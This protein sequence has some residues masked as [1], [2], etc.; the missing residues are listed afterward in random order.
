MNKQ[1]VYNKVRDHLLGMRRQSKDCEGVY[2]YRSPRGVM[3]AAGALIKDEFYSED[4]EHCVVR[5]LNVRNALI[6]SG[7]RDGYL[8]MVSDLQT[9]HDESFNWTKSGKG[10]NVEGKK[11][12][13]LVATHH[14][15]L[16]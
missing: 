2:T 9:V 12:L 11:A 15:L 4:L 7:V 14:G 10:L 8:G 5:D 1:E 16:P 13:A 6:M 3:C